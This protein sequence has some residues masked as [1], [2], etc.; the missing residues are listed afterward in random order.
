MNH[1]HFSPFPPNTLTRDLPYE[2]GTATEQCATEN[3]PEGLKPR[4]SPAEDQEKFGKETKK[5][6]SPVLRSRPG[7][8]S[9]LGPL[10]WPRMTMEEKS[11]PRV[12]TR[13]NEKTV[14]SP[15]HGLRLPWPKVPPASSS[16]AGL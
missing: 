14:P 5:G 8:A 1:R 7:D 12:S 2:E 9:H 11:N 10:A 13:V 6:N 4:D 16:L 15:I 3:T